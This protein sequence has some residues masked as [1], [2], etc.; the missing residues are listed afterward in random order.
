MQISR[1]IS[2]KRIIE[3]ASRCFYTVTNGSVA[4]HQWPGQNTEQNHCCGRVHLWVEREQVQYSYNSPFSQFYLVVD[5]IPT[6]RNF[7]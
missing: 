4:Q 2:L 3:L 7:L 1:K 5:R 6:K